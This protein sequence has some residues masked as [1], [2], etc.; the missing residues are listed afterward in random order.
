MT[1]VGYNDAFD[2]P[3]VPDEEWIR[4]AAEQEW[5]SI[6][7]DRS[8][9][10]EL[11]PLAAILRYNAKIFFVN[12]NRSPK[13]TADLLEAA[14][15]QIARS[16]KKAENKPMLAR[17]YWESKKSSRKPKPR[18]TVIEGVST[19]EKIQERLKKLLMKIPSG[20]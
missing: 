13:E 18:V 19:P 5:I 6:S 16:A 2:D 9:L 12:G 11:R 15:P 4:F 17:V 14:L 10:K 7:C 3:R 20:T 1:V 8:A